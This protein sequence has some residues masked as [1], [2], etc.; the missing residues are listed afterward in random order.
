MST[1]IET[2]KHIE[3]RPGM[4]FSDPLRARSIRIIQA[5]ILGF[6]TAQLTTSRHSEFEC[7]TEWVATRYH[8]LAEGMGG[9]DIIL[10]QTGG[11]ESKAFDEFFRLLPEYERDSQTM[12][13][14]GIL[15]RFCEVQDEC[16]EEFKKGIE[17]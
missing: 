4:Y 16:M 15:S 12:G 6:Q 9:F 11:D 10:Q 7:F 3:K 1:L 2:L 8:V 17:K 13:R 14:D 5:F